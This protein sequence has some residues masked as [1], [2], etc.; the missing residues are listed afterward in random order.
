MYLQQ[1]DMIH[2]VVLPVAGPPILA[3]HFRSSNDCVLLFDAV[4]KSENAVH[5]S[6]EG[7]MTGDW[8]GA[9]LKLL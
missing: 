5:V 6:S 4:W 2:V 9:G 7:R 8:E 1:R 3:R